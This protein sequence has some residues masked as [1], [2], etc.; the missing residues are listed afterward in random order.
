MQHVYTLLV[1]LIGWVLFRSP[2]INSAFTFLN[3]MFTNG[4]SNNPGFSI[5]WF[6]R[7]YNVLILLLCL[8]F[9]TPLVPLIYNKLKLKMPKNIIMLLENTLALLLLIIIIIT[10]VT[11]NYSSFIYF[12]F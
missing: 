4:V 1:I 8:L 2:N 6:L 7:K 3:A 5:G 11:S 12:Q 10:L 9:S